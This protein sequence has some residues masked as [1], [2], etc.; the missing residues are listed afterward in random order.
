MNDRKNKIKTTN[1]I[2]TD[3]YVQADNLLPRNHGRLTRTYTVDNPV[4]TDNL[5]AP[6]TISVDFNKRN[7]LP[8]RKKKIFYFLPAQASTFQFCFGSVYPSKVK[9]KLKRACPPRSQEK[10]QK[11]RN[12][13]IF[14]TDI[15]KQEINAV[16]KV[17]NI[18]DWTMKNPA[19]VGFFGLSQKGAWTKNG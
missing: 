11:K 10:E 19:S 18:I 16:A 15:E 6:L 9:A 13:I 1:F 4:L 2:S 12:I 17:N 14:A 5:T 3:H 8:T 7:N